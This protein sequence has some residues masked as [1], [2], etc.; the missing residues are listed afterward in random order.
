MGDVNDYKS[1]HIDPHKAEIEEFGIK[2][3]FDAVIE[4][5]GIDVEIVYIDRS[6]TNGIPN[7]IKYESRLPSGE[8][9]PGYR[10][11]IRLLY[12]IP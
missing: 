10:D 3:L 9:K 11:T 12:S 7:I 1:R 2:I 6:E 8:L 4:Q 5:A